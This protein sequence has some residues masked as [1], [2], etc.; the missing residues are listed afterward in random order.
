MRKPTMFR[1]RFSGLP[2]NPRSIFRASTTSRR[3]TIRPIVPTA[4]TKRNGRLRR[5]LEWIANM[6]WHIDEK[7]TR[8]GGKSFFEC[9]TLL[10]FSK[11]FQFIR[12]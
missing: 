7:V 3:R 2:A 10:E 9:V 6:P 4:T 5:K 11:V 1:L 8:C 12:V